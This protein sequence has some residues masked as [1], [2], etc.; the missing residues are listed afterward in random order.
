MKLFSIAI[1]V[2]LI[3]ISQNGF[4]QKTKKDKKNKDKNSIENK[5]NNKENKNL[6]MEKKHDYIFIIS[7]KFGDIE[8]YLYDETPLHKANF[9]KL[10]NEKFFDGTTFHR[11]I[12]NFMIQGGD[13]NSKD[14]DP[15]NDGMGSPGYTIPAEFKEHLKHH[16]GAV[17]A[18]RMG[19]NVNPKKESSGSQF[20]IVQNPNG[21][22]FLDGN[23]TVFGKVV[24]GLDIVDKIV[25]QPRDKRDRPYEDIKMT[26]RAV[27]MSK[28]EIN[29]KYQLNLPVSN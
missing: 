27:P 16:V 26:I 1:F 18:A 8:I 3:I 29:Q 28:K 22:P 21:T 17:A 25:E 15:N 24:K 23:Y 5:I 19:D 9:I 13:I 11:I 12:P 6:P 10:V 7:T 2:L 20:Y 14:T 4:A